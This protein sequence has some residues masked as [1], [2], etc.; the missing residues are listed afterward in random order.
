MDATLT[1]SLLTMGGLGI[2]FAGALAIAD[3]KLRVE[4][5]PRINAVNDVLPGANCGACGEAGCQAFAVSVVEGRQEV[6]GCPVGGADTAEAVATVMGVDAGDTV[7]IVARVHCRGGKGLVQEKATY[8]GPQKCSARILVAGGEHSCMWGCVGG[9]DCVEACSFDAIFMN[10]A[11]LPEII[12]EL[13]TGCGACARACP[14]NVIEMHPNTR[15]HFVFCRSHDDPKTSRK[16]CKVACIG[17]G[18]CTRKVEDSASMDN[19]LAVIDY[20]KLNPAIVPFEKCP[21]GAIGPYTR[22]T[23]VRA[24][25]LR[26][27]LKS[28]MPQ[29]PA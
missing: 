9:G 10:E 22:Y 24:G 28:P 8:E 25:Q 21:T 17:C 7:K 11:G 29:P 20:E 23:Q 12:D 27:A 6:N 19:G 4:E 26:G 2:F 16:T 15:E 1:L 13:C 3:R 5:D 14:R 18:I